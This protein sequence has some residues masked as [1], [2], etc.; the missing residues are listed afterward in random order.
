MFTAHT[1]VYCPNA[2]VTHVMVCGE[3]VMMRLPAWALG[4][5]SVGRLQ[6]PLLL[7]IYVRVFTVE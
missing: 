7:L 2:I 6:R 3:T 1:Y 5:I 4:V